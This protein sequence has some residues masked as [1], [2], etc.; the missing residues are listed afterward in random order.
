MLKPSLPTN[1]LLW[2]QTVPEP[3]S[4]HRLPQEAPAVRVP[5]ALTLQRRLNVG[6]IWEQKL[7]AQLEQRRTRAALEAESVEGSGERGRR[8]RRWMIERKRE[9]ERG[10]R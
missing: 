7:R 8:G 6:I 3:E 2:T 9:R 1:R 4:P 5:P 10:D